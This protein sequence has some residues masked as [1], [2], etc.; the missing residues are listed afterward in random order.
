MSALNKEVFS[1]PISIDPYFLQDGG[2][3]GELI[4][5]T[6][7]LQTPLGHPSCWPRCLRTSV[8]LIL[9][10][11]FP[12]YIAWGR[13]YTQLY[14]DA[15]RSV[16]GTTKHPRALG[17][18]SRITFSEIWDTM[19]PMFADVMNGN[20][21]RVQDF[22]LTI[23]RNG[24]PEK[25]YFDYSSSPIKFEDG[26]IGGVLVMLTET[27]A[28]V[29]ALRFSNDA[30]RKIEIAQSETLRQRDRLRRFLMQ[31][32]TGMCVCDG[33]DLIFE[34]VNPSCQQLVPGRDL[35]GRPLIEALPEIQEHPLWD[36]LKNVYAT[37]ST[38]EGKELLIPLAH[39]YNGP[40]EERYFNVIC[41]ARFNGEG[42]VDGI[43]LFATEV[44]DQVVARKELEKTKDTLN[45]SLMAAELGTFDMDLE[46]NT[47]DWNERSRTLFG[48]HHTEPVSYAR[49]FV[50]G[51]HPEDRQRVMTVIKNVYK[52]QVSNGDY[53]VEYRTVGIEDH[54]VRWVRAKGKAYFDDHD[55]PVRFVGA[56]L[57][58][59]EQKN[60]ELRKND[61]IGMVSHELKTPLTSLT[62]LVQ[63]LQGK[64]S[65]LGD[66]T[67]IMMLENANK[68]VKKM[69]SMIN[70]FLNISRLESGKIHLN[71]QEFELL[72]LI[73][74]TVDETKMMLPTHVINLAYCTPVNILADKDKISAV[75]ANLLSNAVKYS[76]RGKVV[77]LDCK[78]THKQIK[79]SVTDEGMGIR[80]ADIKRIF[81]RYYRVESNHRQHISGFG[82]GLYLSAEIIERHGGKIG[83]SSHPGKGSSFW[84]TLPLIGREV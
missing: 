47:L 23:Y 68:Q 74:E 16:L 78:V 45:L 1:D 6:D 55:K 84:F 80:Q 44:T 34:L 7:W 3:M 76:P 66:T 20:P 9:N 22:E 28:K 17:I 37:G 11:Y 26:T 4:R 67:S 46:N 18:S 63:V 2:D 13:H 64:V 14:N 75:I 62:A 61:F 69:S 33:P 5:S 43:H 8:S 52:K 71:M 81:E 10:S 29:N 77:T 72:E 48:I 50:L 56:A 39:T 51:L 54:K 57:D 24:F 31:A 70:S 19:G 73:S 15:F 25:C 58:I 40:P 38:F 12:M 82:I 36:S 65:K 53:D 83:A 60:D 35:L 41:Q 32:P 79:V 59:T 30:K 42:E 49:E 27:T 21:A